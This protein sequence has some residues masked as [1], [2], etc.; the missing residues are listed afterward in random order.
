MLPLISWNSAISKAVFRRS[1]QIRSKAAELL[2]GH[3]WRGTSNELS[4]IRPCSVTPWWKRGGGNAHTRDDNW[5]VK[6]PEPSE[7][8]PIKPGQVIDRCGDP[9]ELFLGAIFYSR[10]NKRQRAY[11]GL[12]ILCLFKGTRKGRIFSEQAKQNK[13]ISN[14]QSHTPK[15]IN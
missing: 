11:L 13:Y 14:Q 3:T 15:Q 4:L 9:V 7:L 12:F 10:D 6:E 8:S 5:E 1:H 2:V